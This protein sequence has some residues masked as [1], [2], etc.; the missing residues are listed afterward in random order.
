MDFENPR[1]LFWIKKAAIKRSIKKYFTVAVALFYV[2]FGAANFNFAATRQASPMRFSSDSRSRE[3]V[4]AKLR[5][6]AGGFRHTNPWYFPNVNADV[7]GGEWSEWID[8]S[9][10]E[11]NARTDRAGGIA[12]WSSMKLSV[13]RADS[14]A[15]VNDCIF[16][17][18]LADQPNE[19]GIVINFTEKSASNSIA[20]LV[21]IPLRKNAKEFETGSQMTVRH[22]KW[23]KEA[24]GGK[25]NP[26]SKNSTLLRSCGDIMILR[27]RTSGSA[28]AQ[29][30][31]G[32]NV[33]GNT[34]PAI[35]RE[36]NLRT[37]GI[38]WLYAARTGIVDGAMEG[39]LRKEI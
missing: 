31:S 8:L 1:I 21:P 19:K 17:V 18:Q 29:V 35:L 25:I 10:W 6:T 27:S 9:K 5:V 30:R 23:A 22:A 14:G 20:F 16:D 13:I 28:V 2:L 24:T 3:P 7:T 11:W 33:S 26:F 4:G 36:R 15:V 37:Y 38:T 32:F 39:F 34:D 12:E